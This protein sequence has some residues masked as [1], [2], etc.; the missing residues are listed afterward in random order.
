MFMKIK[1]T[2]I[3][4]LLLTAVLGLLL[5]FFSLQ[6]LGGNSSP[7]VYKRTIEEVIRYLDMSEST[8]SC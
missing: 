4:K 5:K 1:L 8:L 3:E 6:L 2:I 7:N